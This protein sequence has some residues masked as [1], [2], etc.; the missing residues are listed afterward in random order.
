MKLF[1]YL[2]N[3]QRSTTITTLYSHFNLNLE[4]LFLI[5][6]HFY[7]IGFI[8]F[9]MSLDSPWYLGSN[10][11][12]HLAES[13]VSSSRNAIKVDL[14]NKIVYDDPAVFRHQRVDQVNNDSIWFQSKGN[15]VGV[16]NVRQNGQKGLQVEQYQ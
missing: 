5:G 12:N 3:V 2:S 15:Y 1:G 7:L 6:C 16:T 11:L 4:P 9:T 13:I 14:V 10:T 8:K